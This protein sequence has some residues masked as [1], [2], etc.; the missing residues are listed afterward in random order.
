MYSHGSSYKKSKNSGLLGGVV[1]SLTGLIPNDVLQAGDLE[2]KV[3]WNSKVES[4]NAS[5]SEVSDLENITNIVAEE[6][7]YVSSD[8]S[9]ADNMVDNITPK[10]TQTRTFVLRQPLRKL[11]F[12]DM[13]DVNDVLEL[14]TKSHV[15][16]KRSFEPVKLFALDVELSAMSG[17]TNGII[18][19]LFTFEFSMNKAKELAIY[20][21]II[22]N[23]NLRKVNSHS[24][25]E[26]IVKEISVDLPKS[27][28]E[29]LIGLWQKAY[30]KFELLNMASSVASKWS[31][32]VNKNSVHVA[33]TLNDKELWV[34]R[35]YHQTLLYTLPVGTTAHDLSDLVNSYDSVMGWSNKL[36]DSKGEQNCRVMEI[37]KGDSTSMSELNKYRF[38]VQDQSHKIFQLLFFSKKDS[39]YCQQL[40]IT[41]IIL[42]LT[43]ALLEFNIR[44]QLV[45]FSHIYSNNLQMLQLYMS[46]K[47]QQV[48]FYPKMFEYFEVVCFDNK[49]SKLATI[50]SVLV[51]KSCKQFGH[52]SDVCSIGEN[53]GV[54]HRRVVS[55]QDQKKQT[56]VVFVG[57]SP[58][59][60]SLSVLSGAGL[61][62]S[63][64]LL[65]INSNPLNDF[66]LAK[67][68]ASLKHSLE[69]L[70]DQVSDILKKLRLVN[71]VPI[72]S[73][74]CAPLSLVAPL[75]NS[76][77][78]LNMA[79]NGVVM[80]SSSSFPLVDKTAPEL[81]LSSSKV[82][83]TK[84]GVW[85]IATYN[86]WG[87]NNPAKQ[88]DIVRWHKNMGSLILIITETKLQNRVCSWIA[89]RFDGVWIFTSGVD[90][91]NLGS[92]VAIIMDIFLACHVCKISEVLNQLLS[93]RLFFKNKLFVSILG[94][95]AGASLSVWFSQVGE[96]NFIIAKAVNKSSFVVLDNNFNEDG[97]HKCA[98]FRKC[99]DFGLVNSF[100]GSFFV[101]TST[102]TN[103]C[104]M[105]KMINFLFI[106]LNLVNAVIDHNV[107]GVGEF[108]DTDH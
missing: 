83:T 58:S 79:V 19:A 14:H 28:I 26:V 65:V 52:I 6:T 94:L 68:L 56:P 20:K 99:L 40:I 70:S 78:D 33:L 63:M 55:S 67:C 22:V 27:V 44:Y 104:G 60:V 80:P 11:S 37:I 66:G 89:D 49:A 71:L 97:F 98:S 32:F 10:K 93:V 48:I 21:K 90:F 17:K 4:E 96:I 15:L 73:L 107:C 108:F 95:Y 51:Y 1:D 9:E 81:S 34:A 38:N 86:V 101:K 45:L 57:S 88:E 76:A 13:S 16:K 43:S 69:L 50:D 54:C 24:N 72:L 75:L 25:W 35:D 53:S 102:W 39:L 77:L 7:S 91:G 64:K 87:I 12:N 3:S 18:R 23:D 42:C 8:N 92:S 36:M 59:Y 103:S 106:F 41:D 62:L 5:I 47:D 61:L 105:A 30:M 84:V 85:K 2:H 100:G 74:P 31:V 82:F 29:S 46:G